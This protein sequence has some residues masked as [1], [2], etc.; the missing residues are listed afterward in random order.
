MNIRCTAP[1]AV[2]TL[3]F[4]RGRYAGSGTTRTANPANTLP[5]VADRKSL[6]RSIRTR[7]GSP[8]AGPYGSS[9][10]IAARSAARMLSRDGAPGVTAVPHTTSV[11][12]STNHVTHGLT[13]RPSTSTSTGASK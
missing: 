11:P 8:P 4:K 13:S 9:T 12:A 3:P 10:R 7:P 2:S 6:P 5:T 1:L